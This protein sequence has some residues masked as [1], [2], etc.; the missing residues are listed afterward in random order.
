MFNIFVDWEQGQ[1]T[2][3][4]FIVVIEEAVLLGERPWWDCL[5]SIWPKQYWHYW[6]N[7]FTLEI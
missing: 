7:T 2:H 4:C 3:R 1:D 6:W 5:C